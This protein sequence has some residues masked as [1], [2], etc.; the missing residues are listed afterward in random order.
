MSVLAGIRRDGESRVVFAT[1]DAGIGPL[2]PGDR[3]VVRT[4]DGEAEA[5]V[6]I[7]PDQ[8]IASAAHPPVVGTV[9]ARS[10]VV[11]TSDAAISRED[12]AYRSRKA[13]YPPL[14]SREEIAEDAGTVVRIDLRHERF[15]VRTGDGRIVPLSRG[16]ARSPDSGDH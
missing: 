2:R 12:A 13:T 7:G 11:S 5:T 14:G 15:E 16:N 1:P 8:M 9:V 4:A 3:V 10:A 6:A